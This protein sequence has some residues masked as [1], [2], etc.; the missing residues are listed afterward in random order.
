ML[1]K[2]KIDE[3]I[4][5]C[6]KKNKTDIKSIA[7]ALNWNATS[8]EK[9]GRILA[10]AGLIEMHYPVNPLELPWISIKKFEKPHQE[11]EVEGKILEEY[12]ISGRKSMPTHTKIVETKEKQLLYFVSIPTVSIYTKE[13]FNAI[14]DVVSKKLQAEVT[15]KTNEE[16]EYQAR[17][18]VIA[19]ILES[20]LQL[21][22]DELREI[23]TLVINMI[24]GLGD[25]EI[26]MAD[27]KLEEI[28][29]NSSKLPVAVYHRKY[30]WLKTNIMLENEEEIENYAAQIGRKIGREINLLHP[31]LD[32]HLLSGDRVNATLAPISTNGNTLTIRMFA[33]NPWTITSFLKQP[34][35]AL[36]IEMAALLWQ[37]VH[38][39][40]NII[41]AGGTGS[42]KTSA[43]N[44]LVALIPP[45]QRVITIEDTR[46]LVLPRYMWNWVPLVTRQPNPE[47]VGEVTM[48]D[49]LV[50]SL[51][52]RPDRI[53]MGEI[54]RKKEAEV[55]FEATHTGHSIYAT[56]HA[57]T[58]S[59]VIKRLI[60]PP[61]E[62]PASEVEDIQLL[63]VQYRDRRK[64]IRRTLELCEVVPGA[65]RP[66]IN[67]IYL[68]RPRTDQFQFVKR[69][70]RY[71]EELNL[72]T[73]MTEKE[74][75]E[76]Q[77]NKAKVLTWMINNN[78]IN[79]ND[80]GAVMRA[81]YADEAE[82]IKAAEKRLPPN[83]ILE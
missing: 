1:V 46:E 20:D 5:F 64:N 40:M 23:T 3:M 75:A 53:V 21:K 58:A 69:P 79:M 19:E 15:G 9:I 63:L 66:D 35:A 30:G 11:K 60:E 32:A 61:L 28:A 17:Y 55:L 31:I 33:K 57:D 81:Y 54:R 18:K 44:T 56:L 70:A 72:H 36:S 14:R 47:G 29:V 65:E 67:H 13:Y 34:G 76:D 43:L 4:E 25:L 78:L 8:V 83:K 62:V 73:G 6:A 77:K 49:L 50:N 16:V 12:D 26:L 22:K 27:E 52:M 51:R 82:V 45:H 48:L 42:G 80:V 24:Y 68:W 59:Q 10:K 38:Y 37:A 2:T 74:I 71:I 7:E 41:I 39:E